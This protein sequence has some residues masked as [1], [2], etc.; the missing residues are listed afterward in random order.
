MVIKPDGKPRERTFVMIKPDGV[1]R[2]IAGEIITRLERKG[3]Q[4][5]AI[6]MIRVDIELAATH[7]AEHKGKSFYDGLIEFI[8]SSPVIA[9]VWEGD[10]SIALVRKMVGATR[11]EDADPGTIRGDFAISTGCNLVHASDGLETAHRE[12]NLWFTP[13][14]LSDYPMTV[15]PWL[16][17]HN[18]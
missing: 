9:M 2:G 17:R 3:L 18:G 15:Q 13:G 8:T 10:N 1:Q 4:P 14:E 12:I 11:P 5:V 16:H 6:K 7:Y